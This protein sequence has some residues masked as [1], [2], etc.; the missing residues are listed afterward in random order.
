MLHIT[1]AL[2]INGSSFFEMPKY[3]SP[4]KIISKKRYESVSIGADFFNVANAKITPS[5]N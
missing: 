5:A 4:K 1:R 2:M 3:K